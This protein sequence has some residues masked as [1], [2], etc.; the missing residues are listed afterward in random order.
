M[1][2]HNLYVVWVPLECTI[3]NLIPFK[4]KIKCQRHLSMMS[5]VFGNWSNRKQQQ[6]LPILLSKSARLNYIE[7]Q[8]NNKTKANDD[9]SNNFDERLKLS[10]PTRRTV[11]IKLTLHFI[12]MFTH[13]IL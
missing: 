11:S 1:G 3:N 9:N 12:H 2:H 7:N 8:I 4:I 6:T 5:D 13:G 10:R